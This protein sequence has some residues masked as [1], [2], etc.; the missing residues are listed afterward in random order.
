MQ[1]TFSTKFVVRKSK[2]KDG[3][4]PVFC[5]ITVGGRRSEFSIKRKVLLASWGNGMMKGNSE[6][7]RTLNSYMK[8]L[9]AKVFD[10]IES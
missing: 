4:V 10:S 2:L 7:V 3:L 1:T 6:E 9:D 5:R 8:L